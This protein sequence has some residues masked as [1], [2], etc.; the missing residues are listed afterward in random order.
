M[1]RREKGGSVRPFR[2]PAIF[3]AAVVFGAAALVAAACG[4]S[5][6]TGSSSATSAAPQATTAAGSSSG[7]QQL[8]AQAKKE[9]QVTFYSSQGVDQLNAVAKAFEAKYGITVN[10]SRN[11]DATDEAKISAENSSGKR[12]A[13]VVSFADSNYVQSKGQLG[14]WTPPTGPD[15][16]NPAYDKASNVQSDGSFVTSAAVYAIGWN[17]QLVPK[18]ISSYSQILDP[19]FK[20]KIGIPD[21]ATSPVIVDFYGYVQQQTSSDFLTSLAALKPQVFSSVLQ[22]AQNLT[23]GQVAVGLAV[24]PL[25]TQK[26]AGAPVDFIVPKPA[27]GARFYTTIVKNSP[28]PAAAQLLADF[29]VTPEGQAA[30]TAQGASVLPNT[31]GAVAAVANVRAI[32]PANLQP[33]H[34]QQFDTK[35]KSLFQ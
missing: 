29:L 33:A 22:I 18:G 2:G 14:W 5:G 11:I 17:T 7:W 10:I 15:F 26:Q 20:G 9:G 13:D 30:L 4:S 19:Q 28:H 25:V 8:V 21:A 24:A 12:I 16:N 3:K 35:F 27:W 32:D 23:S 6:K 1:C 34:V 31:P